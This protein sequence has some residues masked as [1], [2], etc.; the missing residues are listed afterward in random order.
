MDLMADHVKAVLVSSVTFY[1][2]TSE[3]IGKRQSYMELVA[4]R[5]NAADWPHYGHFHCQCPF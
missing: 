2:H 1:Y 5:C 4:H 3:S